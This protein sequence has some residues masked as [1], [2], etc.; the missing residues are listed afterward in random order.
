MSIVLILVGSLM[1][2]G[3][4]AVLFQ[5]NL[6]MSII[7]MGV[8]SLLATVMFV[9]MKAYDVAIT[10]AAIGAVLTI[11]LFLF[12]MKRLRESGY[13]EGKSDE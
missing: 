13:R 4:I 5:K 7:V 1:V 10:E 2:A 8:V 3:S 6:V 11:A 9:L 12:A